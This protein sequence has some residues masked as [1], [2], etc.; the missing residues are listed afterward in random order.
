MREYEA[1]LLAERDA[2]IRELM[3][4]VTALRKVMSE[5]E[6]AALPLGLRTRIEFALR[7]GKQIT[8]HTYVSW[9]LPQ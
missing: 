5:R 4:V 9:V 3:D 8:L 7:H 2:A 1:Q 6:L